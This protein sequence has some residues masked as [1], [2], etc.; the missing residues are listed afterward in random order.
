MTHSNLKLV[1]NEKGEVE[2]CVAVTGL[3]EEGRAEGESS[4]LTSMQKLF[5]A[6]RIKDAQKAANDK[7]F[8]A[9]LLAEFG[10]DK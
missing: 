10:L 2:M 8:C 5:A 6:G 3:R 7:S 9:K 4:I 1:V